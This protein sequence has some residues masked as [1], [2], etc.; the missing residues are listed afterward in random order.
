L[1]MMVSQV[2]C[3][4]YNKFLGKPKLMDSKLDTLHM[5]TGHW[6]A[7]APGLGVAISD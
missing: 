6:K 2:R 1:G 3:T 7:F 4:V 5:H